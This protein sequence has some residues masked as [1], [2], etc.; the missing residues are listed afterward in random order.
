MP[1]NE[2]QSWR[3]TITGLTMAKIL[4][5]KALQYSSDRVPIGKVVTQPY[6][7]ISPAMQDEYYAS[8]PNNLI[9]ILRGRSE[10]GDSESA[11]VY[12][13]AAEYLGQWRRDGIIDQA[14][15][16][17]LFAYF[18]R[19]KVPG[20]DE[21]R[22][23][24]GFIGLCRLEDYANKVVFPHEKT[25]TGPKQDRLELLRHT[26]THFGQ[27]FLMYSDP[28]QRVDAFLDEVARGPAGFAV[29]DEHEVEHLVWPIS[30]G[31]T[32]EAI[33]R[34]MAKRSLLIAD[35]HHRYET[36]LAFRDE[37]RRAGGSH[38]AG[39]YEWL[40]TTMVNMESPGVAI[41]PTHR[42]ISNLES[43]DHGG[44]LGRAA[45]YFDLSEFEGFGQFEADL[46]SSSSG[47]SA[48]GVF[49][50]GSETYT[51]L[52][53]K[54]GLDIPRVLP[55]VT[56]RQSELDVVIL[57][58]LIL[59]RCMGISEDDVRGGK[60]LSYVRG[61]DPAIA[62]VRDGDAQVGFLLNA[63]RMDQVRDIAF[64]GDVMPQK[65]TDFYP[66]VL[67]GLTMYCMEE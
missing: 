9:R 61:L 53:P 44:L 13:R 8:H 15:E 7:K 65:S 52:R 64:G 48:I 43:Y 46:T 2:S 62:K 19:F 50:K 1:S 57:H 11:S 47:R 34:E 37:M 32:I 21:I 38:D 16:P 3:G 23:R 42:V 29:T 24:K 10:P 22:T 59:D 30:D 12:T 39:P 5:F 51:V 54:N 28:E 35:G 17:L 4:P 67:S 36:A 60:Y 55:G 41:L 63:T 6:D 26:R 27:V 31:G 66:K 33:Q 25:L 20:S 45:E 49:G 14:N 56:D 58:R 40:M 18:Q